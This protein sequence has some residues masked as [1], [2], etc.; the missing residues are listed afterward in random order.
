[1]GLGDGRWAAS[2]ICARRQLAAS[3]CFCLAG[4]L[5]ARVLT[6]CLVS[7]AVPLWRR[8]EKGED[9]ANGED[10]SPESP[11]GGGEE[12]ED[13]DEEDED[14]VEWLAD[15]SGGC[16]ISCRRRYPCLGAPLVCVGGCGL[17]CAGPFG[18]LGCGWR[19][20]VHGWCGGARSQ[21][22]VIPTS[23][24]RPGI[25]APAAPLRAPPAAAVGAF[26]SCPAG[27]GGALCAGCLGTRGSCASAAP[28][29]LRPG[30]ATPAAWP[31]VP[32]QSQ[33]HSRRRVP[34]GRAQSCLVLGCAVARTYV[35]LPR[36]LPSGPASPSGHA[37]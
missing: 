35:S 5:P 20:A 28:S 37:T 15:T 7:T 18:F 36:C 32:T 31:V 29:A 17:R 27:R 33:R 12:D 4:P 13:E 34:R 26:N 25:H 21:G 30:P 6:R 16:R 3:C 11:E 2:W 19:P 24:A 23:R 14:D 1:M 22:R 10:K 8:K 9:G